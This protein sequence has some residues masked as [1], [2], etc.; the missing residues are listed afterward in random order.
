MST[1]PFAALITAWKLSPLAP[2]FAE[3]SLKWL[4]NDPFDPTR[5]T[6]NARNVPAEAMIQNEFCHRNV[7][8]VPR[9]S[10]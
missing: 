8:R 5:R 6:M 9:M 10:T 2:N 7:V 1:C 4:T 3:R